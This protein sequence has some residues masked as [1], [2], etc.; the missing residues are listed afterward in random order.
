MYEGVKSRYFMGE[1]A[2]RRTMNKDVR[3]CRLSV[4][5]EFE[6]IGLCKDCEVKKIDHFPS[7]LQGK[8]DGWV[9]IV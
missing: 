2:E 7:N 8:L 9:K 4:N 1:G 3:G 6:L 5:F